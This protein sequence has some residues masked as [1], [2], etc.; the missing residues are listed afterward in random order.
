MKTLIWSAGPEPYSAAPPLYRAARIAGFDVDIT[1]DRSRAG[2]RAM[3][4]ML[5]RNKYDWVFLF[6][7]SVGYR[8]AYRF[9]RQSEVK[10][11]SWYPDQLNDTR[12]KA[13]KRMVDCFDVVVCSS[14]RTTDILCDIGIHAIWMPQYFELGECLPLPKRLDKEEAIHDVCFIGGLDERRS[15]FMRHLSKH[16]DLVLY[17]PREDEQHAVYG[18]DMAKVYAQSKIAVNVQRE[19]YVL[20]GVTNFNVSNRVFRAMGSGSF[21]LHYSASNLQPLFVWGLDY[22]THD[23]TLDG[24]VR[25]VDYWLKHDDERE[26]IALAG[27]D[28]VLKN[29]TLEQRIPQYWKL[30]EDHDAQTK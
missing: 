21:F 5:G 3:I 6:V 10:L 19:A 25:K 4:D 14:K 1:G 20:S 16:F 23:D 7:S 22:D 15:K 12:I 27:R 8:N 13:W 24:L 26:K 30:M 17:G 18:H 2:T 9:I 11:L 29:H 28:K